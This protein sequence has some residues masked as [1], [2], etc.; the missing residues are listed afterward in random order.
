MLVSML[1]LH[2]ITVLLHKGSRKQSR[3][4]AQG[5]YFKGIEDLGEIPLL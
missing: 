1:Q 4:S 5:L 3:M 2:Y